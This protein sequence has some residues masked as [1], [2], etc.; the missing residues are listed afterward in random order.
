MLEIAD[1]C[2]S[3]KSMPLKPKVIII[4]MFEPE[5]GPPGEFG[6]YRDREKMR[7][8]ELP[9]L[10]GVWASP[11]G[12]LLG[13]LAGVGTANT[14]VFIMALGLCD[15]LDLTETVWL[16]SG[17]AGGNPYRCSLGSP[18]WADWC[19]DGDLAFEFDVRDLP[20][21]WSTG[22]LPLAA[23]EPFGQPVMPIELFG[24]PYQYFK[25]NEVYLQRAYRLTK[26]IELFDNKALANLRGAYTAIPQAM[27]PPALHIGG[28]LSA[29]RFWHGPRHNAWADQWVQHWSGG[30]SR[31]YTSAM[32]DT[33]TLL[34]LS[35]LEKMGRTKA[36]R[37][38]IL[39][40]VSNFTMPPNGGNIVTSLTGESDGGEFPGHLVAVENSYRV[41]ST[42]YRDVIAN[43]GEWA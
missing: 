7:R 12:E 37:T 21:D 25:L 26:D 18:V 27:E 31:F 19:A 16:I 24:H 3:Y 10:E 32:E 5:D 38:L 13:V 42:V 36:S 33:G 20:E 39:R 4:C 6:L 41:A 23:R 43:P 15:A 9:G 22:I 8:L 11:D 40:T 17:I 29:A 30:Q 1:K 28:T 14:A 34:A 2:V 35:R